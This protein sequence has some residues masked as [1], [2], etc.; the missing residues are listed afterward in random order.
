MWNLKYDT[1]EHN[2]STKQKLTQRINKPHGHREQAAGC[3][4]EESW[5]MD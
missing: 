3:Q 2:Y 4:E 1:N 5:W